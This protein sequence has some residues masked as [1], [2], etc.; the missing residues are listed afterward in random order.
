MRIVLQR[1]LEGS[2]SVDGEII[3]AIERGFVLLVG[4]AKGDDESMMDAMARKIANLRIFSDDAG[5]M[6]LSLLDVGGEAL[7]ISQFTLL[8]DLTQGRRPSFGNAEVPERAS[9]L[10]DYFAASLRTCSVKHVATGRFGADMK[11]ALVNDG[12]V[13]IIL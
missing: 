12:P 2:V 10:C 3:G 4:I 6:N 9:V 1:V 5:K 7:V 13:T 11:V 8:A